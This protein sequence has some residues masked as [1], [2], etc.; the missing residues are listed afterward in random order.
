M[1]YQFEL[2][3]SDITRVAGICGIL[4]PVVM[5]SCLGLSIASSPW[6]SWT[7]HALS[8]LGIQQ[9]TAALFNYGMIIGG[10][11]T[12]IFS[13]GL[14]KILSKRTGAYLLMVSSFA[15]IGIGVFPETVFYLHFF[16]SASFFV[17]LTV[18]FLIIGVTI[19]QNFFEKS[20]GFLALLIALIAM[21]SSLF[22]FQ[23]K[24]IAL[25]EAF[26]CFPGFMWCLIVGVKMTLMQ[27]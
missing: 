1:R 18:S 19:K 24:G 25:S 21:I 7:E 20:I 23:L 16:T 13:L 2:N 3:K 27:A 4:L 17:I 15:L 8:D 5:F 11:L 12:F 14:I 6:F 22:L 26:S 10:I 9:S